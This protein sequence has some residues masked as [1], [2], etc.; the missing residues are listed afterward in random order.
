ML[1]IDKWQ[2]I[3]FT[4]RKNK[5]RTFLTAFSVAWGIFILMILLG[6]GTGLQHGVEYDFRDDAI[7][8]IWISPGQTSKPFKGM[9]PGRRLT[10]KSEDYEDIRDK[11]K[12]VE[13]AATRFHCW[14]NFTVRYKDNYSSFNVLGV[15]PEMMYLENQTPIL[16]RYINKLDIIDRRKVAVLGTKVV[17][18]LF[19][20]NENPI[21]KWIDV[22]SIKYLV[23]GVYEDKGDEGEMKNVFIPLTTAQLAYNAKNRVHS[24][25]YTV[26]DASV[27][28]SRAMA[29]QTREILSEKYKFDLTD[30][31]AMFIW[32]NVENFQKFKNLFIGVKLFLWIIGVFTIIAGIVGVSNIMFIV[33]KDRTRE[34]GVRK[35]IG[36]TPGSI[37]G[38]FLQESILITVVA[39]YIGLITGIGVIEFIKW[40]LMEFNIDAPYFRDP[41]IDLFTAVLAT[42]L[43]V[44]S[45]AIAGYF[46]ARKAAKVNP[47]VALK[48][49]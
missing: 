2:E 7:N 36:A 8:S 5:L 38:L 19:D 6:V 14:G 33:I 45:G 29:E 1:D 27:K 3:F 49:E 48:E 39:G 25:M 23:V 9:K 11:I 10:L 41:E 12:G 15:S 22:R 42:V 4:I 40:A 28:E 26:G 20:K 31:R 43:L 21:G 46:P 35:A 24:I 16:G 44:V 47:I 30:D 32:N 37:I 13:Y 17:E 18:G 34:I